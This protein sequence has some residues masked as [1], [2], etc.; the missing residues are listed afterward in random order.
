MIC[1]DTFQSTNRDRLV[2]DPAAA[3][4]GF[5]GSIANTAE[6]AGKDVGFPVQHVSVAELTL[7]D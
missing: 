6:D 5:A 2:L 3:A 4:G 7:G 1:R